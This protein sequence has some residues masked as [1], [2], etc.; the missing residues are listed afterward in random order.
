MYLP[1][2][3]ISKGVDS[4]NS[5]G[6]TSVSG[7]KLSRLGSQ[8]SFSSKQDQHSLAQIAEVNECSFE[9][10]SSHENHDRNKRSAPSQS[11]PVSRFS[12]SQWDD[13]NSQN[14]V[15][16]ASSSRQG[17][18]INDDILNGLA[19]IDAQVILSCILPW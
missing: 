3:S 15:F 12:L 8:L 1:G 6:S 4:Y 10:M 13:S 7:H 17:K 9:R 19:S 2:F 16:A 14:I 11:H 18:I 5:Q